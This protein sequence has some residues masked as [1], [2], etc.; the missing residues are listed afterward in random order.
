MI[1]PKVDLMSIVGLNIVA[2]MYVSDYEL[3]KRSWR[4]RLFTL[5]WTP[6][7]RFKSVYVPPAYIEPN[8]VVRVSPKTKNIIMQLLLDKADKIV[9]IKDN[10]DI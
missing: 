9:P 1:P 3:V 2:D 5:P 8:G 10:R 6:L 4:E 7:K